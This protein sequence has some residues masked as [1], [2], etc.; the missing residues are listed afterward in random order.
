VAIERD[1]F[2]R[3]YVGTNEHDLVAAITA[4]IAVLLDKS[5]PAP[6]SI[7]DK[8]EALFMLAHF[9]GDLHQPLHVAAVYLDANGQPV[10]PDAA[11]GVDPT[12]DTEG[13]NLIRDQHLVF[14]AEW[15]A[16]PE[17]LGD[18]ATPALLSAAKSQSTSKGNLDDWPAAWASDTIVVAHDAFAGTKFKQTSPEHWSISFDDRTAY[19][20]SQDKIK[21]Q[22]L[23]KAGARLAELLNAI[24]P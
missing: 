21:R 4:A 20:S 13:G 10:D 15:D 5:A 2:D 1:R 12:T 3:S 19:L 9:V 7:A 6:F 18:A 17:D 14:H 16:I 8:K 23:A 11:H 24:W 22:Q